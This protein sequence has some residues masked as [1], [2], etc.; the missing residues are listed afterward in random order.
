VFDTL[1]DGGNPPV[2][3]DKRLFVDDEKGSLEKMLAEN[4][5][6]WCDKCNWQMREIK[7]GKGSDRGVKKVFH[8]ICLHAW[9]YIVP[10]F[11]LDVVAEPPEWASDSF[12]RVIN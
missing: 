6:E 9:R 11:G 1:Y 8:F 12:V 4:N 7:T 2:S 3:Q 5:V 10:L